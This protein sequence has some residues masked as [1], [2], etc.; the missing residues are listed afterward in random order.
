M[1]ERGSRS[2]RRTPRG[3]DGVDSGGGAAAVVF[4]AVVVVALALVP[5]VM[6]RRAVEAQLD[7]A[8]VLDP[9]RLLGTQLSL[10]QARQMS[11]FQAFLLTGDTTFRQPYLD[12]SAEEREVYADLQELV[13]GM[14]LGVRERLARLS[15]I[16]ARWHLDHQGAFDSETG[17][18]VAAASFASE[19]RRFDELQQ[20]TLALERAI[21]N[22]VDAGRRRVDRL[23]Q[24]QSRVTLVLVVLALG[25]TL[26]VG[27]VGRRLR[28][29][30][31]EAERRRWDAVRARREID[32]LLEATTDGVLGV[33]PSGRAVSLN[34]AGC[35]LLGYTEGDLRG[36]DVHESLHHTTPDGVRRERSAS[37]ILGAL[38]E[39][40]TAE[41]TDVDVFW[42]KDG[43][44]LSVQ[45]FLRPLK[46]GPEPRGSVITFTDMTRIRENEEA[47]RRAVR[48]REEVVA[49]V[50]HDLRNPLGVVAGAADLLLDLPLDEEE[51]H[52]QA[53]VIR[54]SAERM[55][56]LVEDLL[57]MSRIEEG[58]LVIRPTV[59]RADDLLEQARAVFADQAQRVGVELDVA[60]G[61]SDSPSL[62]V[63]ADRIQQ[64]LNN[65]LDNALKFTPRGG[66]VTLAAAARDDGR[67]A[68]SVADSGPGIP[69][70]EVDR[71]FDR[72]WQ[73]SRHDRTG[74]GLGLAIVHGI[75]EA[76]GGAVEVQSEPGS[77]TT[78]T[79]VLPG[80]PEVGR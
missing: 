53:D 27:L 26:V 14:D 15:T 30:T 40:G 65:L 28:A 60:Q 13:L 51:R 19:Q 20:A 33:D 5:A 25:A 21:Q 78:F 58:A 1:T 38:S 48:V 75:T 22:E 10:V 41:S 32:A 7:I 50:S 3:S 16:S 2:R 62:R 63:D 66:R 34:R 56:R 44:P 36:R 12:G 80:V 59:E 37:P 42:R 70:E 57:D 9:A 24:L 71:L 73:A 43:T 45:W 69:K 54:R 29:L 64:G 76:H 74:S 52:K 68:L 8:E 55:G 6:G 39:G 23:R 31:V 17:R 77:G 35:R 49:V 18:S 61:E 4:V 67:V 46:D 11:L 79:L 47:L 72:F